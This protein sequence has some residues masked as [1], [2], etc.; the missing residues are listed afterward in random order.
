MNHQYWITRNAKKLQRKFNAKEDENIVHS[1]LELDSKIELFKS[2]NESTTNLSNIV[3][4]YRD[5]LNVLASEMA[6]LGQF[7]RDCGKNSASSSGVMMNS[8]K[9]INYLGQQHFTG[10]SALTRTS[11]E[12]NTFK[13]AVNDSKETIQAMEKERTEYRAS[14]ALM[15]NCSA[16][17]DP[18]SGRGLEKFRT[19]QKYVKYAKQK[20]DKFSLA[21]L[22]KIDL[23][24]AARCN[25]FSYS[26]A[27]YQNNWM[28]LLLKNQEVLE[29]HIRII[30]NE[31]IKHSFSGVLKEL[32]QEIAS[33]QNV[34]QPEAIELNDNDQRLFFSEEFSDGVQAENKVENNNDKNGVNDAAEVKANEN[35]KLIDYEAFDEFTSSSNILLPSQLLMDDSLFNQNEIGDLLG[36]LMPSSAM[37]S[38]DLIASNQATASNSKENTPLSLNKN[39]SKKSSD[40]SKWF[41]LFSDLDPLNQQKE[42]RDAN[43]NMH[44]A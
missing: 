17:I 21:C 9:V 28:S 39:P 37:Q 36:S 26:L 29:A 42:V 5:A 44:A 1:D 11:Q 12:L 40:I 31:P 8:G 15:K 32:T 10:M 6:N 41:Q 19:S 33:S 2:I 38:S 16:D 35:H 23:L 27:A 18:D 20:F 30:E 4:K 14:L 43:E 7:L 13:R 3:D 25:L 22:Q 34:K 24:S